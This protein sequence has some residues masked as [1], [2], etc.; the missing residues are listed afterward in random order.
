MGDTGTDTRV[1]PFVVF[2]V[3]QGD[4]TRGGTRGGNSG[5]TRDGTGLGTGG[6]HWAGIRLVLWVVPGVVLVLAL[7]II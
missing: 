7:R 5:G 3:V 2:G 4:G 1:S 6:D